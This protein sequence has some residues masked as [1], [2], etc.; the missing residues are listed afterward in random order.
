MA[1]LKIT[2][3]MWLEKTLSEKNATRIGNSQSYF[4][5]H[6]YGLMVHTGLQHVSSARLYPKHHLVTLVASWDNGT[7]QRVLNTKVSRVMQNQA[8]IPPTVHRLFPHHTLILEC[9]L[10]GSGGRLVL[11]SP[12]RLLCAHRDHGSA[13]DTTRHP[14]WSTDLERE[15][16]REMK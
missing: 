14:H 12:R 11:G 7:S 3:L 10:T 5:T 4:Y 1:F 9:V 15:R 2:I 16:E 6:T 8:F 13:V